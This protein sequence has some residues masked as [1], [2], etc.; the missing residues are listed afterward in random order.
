MPM[1]LTEIRALALEDIATHGEI[2]C[3]DEGREDLSADEQLQYDREIQKIVKTLRDQ[4]QRL[5]SKGRQS[6]GLI[7]SPTTS[8]QIKRGKFRAVL[9]VVQRRQAEAGWPEDER[10]T[11]E[12]LRTILIDL[13]AEDPANHQ[14]WLDRVSFE[15]AATVALDTYQE[16]GGDIRLWHGGE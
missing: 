1:K 4:A 8:Y 5:R 14:H 12:E 2:V 9:A 7:V 3:T 16:F 6:D 11:E 15:E 10:M 13:P